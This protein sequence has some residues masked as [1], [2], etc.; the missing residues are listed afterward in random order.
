MCRDWLPDDGV[1]PAELLSV[2][3]DRD[4]EGFCDTIHGTYVIRKIDER[5]M[6]LVIQI[7]TCPPETEGT[8]D[9]NVKTYIEQL[10][11]DRF[12]E[13]SSGP[14]YMIST[15]MSGS[16]CGEKL[17]NFEL[18]SAQLRKEYLSNYLDPNPANSKMRLRMMFHKKGEDPKDYHVR[19]CLSVEFFLVNL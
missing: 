8:C 17:G 2:I 6:E 14:W 9:Q 7:F 13:D 5:D 15:A 10:H 4:A 19:G 12:K 16:K 11:C 18:N 1:H 3:Y